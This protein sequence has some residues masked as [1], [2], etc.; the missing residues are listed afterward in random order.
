MRDPLIKVLVVVAVLFVLAS[1]AFL[2]LIVPHEK[3]EGS[4][5]RRVRAA[6]LI[7]RLRFVNQHPE[8]LKSGQTI[9]IRTIDDAILLQLEGPTYVGVGMNKYEILVNL[10]GQVEIPDRN[11]DGLYDGCFECSVESDSEQIQEV[12]DSGIETALKELGVS[13]SS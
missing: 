9:R 1:A 11:G 2:L 8:Q 3:V 5:S 7:E 4:S 10:N 12:F 13:P 6:A